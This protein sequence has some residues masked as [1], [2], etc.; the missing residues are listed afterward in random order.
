[1][2]FDDSGLRIRQLQILR[3]VVRAGSARLAAK[4]LGISQPAVSQNI[5]QLEDTVGFALFRRESNG[6]APTEKAFELLRVVEAALTGL[7]RVRQ[8]IG[9]LQTIDTTTIAIAAPAIFSLNAIPRAVSKMRESNHAYRF[10]IKSGDY[11]QVSDHVLRGVADLGITRLPLHDEMF[12]WV[13]VGIATNVCL[14]RPDHRFATKKIITADDLIGET[15]VDIDPQVASHQM[16]VNALR[17]VGAKADIAVEYDGNGHDAG[18]V[19]AGI[20]VS[21]TNE[22]IAREYAA[23]GLTSR[24]FQPGATYHYVVFWQKGRQL[25]DTLRLAA[26]HLVAA[27]AA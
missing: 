19:S 5:K 24:R 23:F 17:Y 1:M 22:I 16:S 2:E 21:I 12:D 18:F 4:M 8:S 26:E 9:A 27:I 25:S 10:Q 3:E 6:L 15:L 14:F 11:E 20:G 7:D 13:P